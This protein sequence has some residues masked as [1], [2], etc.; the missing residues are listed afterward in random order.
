M[1]PDQLQSVIEEIA[2]WPL[3]DRRS[4][5]EVLGREYGEGAAEQIKTALKKL[6]ESRK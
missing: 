4:Y 2:E 3:E 5:I 1:T 6:W